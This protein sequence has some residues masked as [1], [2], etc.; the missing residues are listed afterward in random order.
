MTT[1]TSD[2]SRIVQNKYTES[3]AYLRQLHIWLGIG[4][5]G[6]AIS[7]TSLA[8]S[9]PD[10]AYAIRFLQPS[11]WCFLLGVVAAGASVFFLSQKASAMG[12]HYA[13]AHNREQAN[14]A[15]KKI[16]QI[17]SSPQ[18]IADEANGERNALIARS[19][20]EHDRA[21]RSWNASRIW[22][23]LWGA[24]LMVSCLAFVVAFAW[25]LVQISFL[26]ANLAP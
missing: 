16:P 7:M 6:G 11:L 2:A 5:A 19:K 26:G 17:I 24:A 10:P 22:T 18:R 20:E 13:S 12:E 25:P 4:S 21:E 14:Q 23:R 1:D 9:L 8:A 3:E 15:V